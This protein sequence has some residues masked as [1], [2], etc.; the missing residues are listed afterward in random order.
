MMFIFCLGEKLIIMNLNYYR[1]FLLVVETGSLSQTAEIAKIAQPAITRQMKF[2]EKEFGAKLLISGRGK[3]ELKLTDAGWIFYKRAKQLCQL[4]DATY[5][6]MQEYT[7]GMKGTLTISMA[8]SRTPAFISKVAVPFSALYPKIRYE[9]HESFHMQILD[10]V[11]QGI[12]EIGIANATIPDN[13]KFEVLFSRPEQ[14]C[15]IGMR[16]NLWWSFSEAIERLQD[17]GSVPLVVIRSHRKM[18]ES[19]CGEDNFVPNILIEAG[20]KISA[21]NFA[22]AGLAI[23]LVPLEQNEKL[24][25]GLVAVPLNDIRFSVSK[26]MIKLKDHELSAPM[27]KLIDFYKETVV[28][29]TEGV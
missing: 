19:I 20:T 11:L 17:A 10:D 15:L 6:E 18:I 22:Q 4:E 12:S 26:T 9:I 7:D 2:L 23:A 5:R 1:N 25:D 13:Y 27:Q 16:N 21:L 3:H 24:P 14:F 29:N 8:P 28:E